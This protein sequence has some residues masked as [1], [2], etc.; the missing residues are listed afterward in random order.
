MDSLL[1]V[2]DETLAATRS[3]EHQ[4]RLKGSIIKSLLKVT[5]DSLLISDLNTAALQQWPFAFWKPSMSN[6]EPTSSIFLNSSSGSW[7]L[8]VMVPAN[9]HGLSKTN[10]VSK[11][12]H[13]HF[14]FHIWKNQGFANVA[15]WTLVVSK[16][17]S[18]ILKYIKPVQALTTFKI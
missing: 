16:D 7:G 12:P 17:L 2:Q 11:L 8:V 15:T 6:L 4:N 1:I 18:Q 3:Q 9:G 5:K 14:C 10:I 13:W